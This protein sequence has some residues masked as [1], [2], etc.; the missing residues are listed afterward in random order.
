MEE[1]L[2]LYELI[3]IPS[4][5]KVNFTFNGGLSGS[6][7]VKLSQVKSKTNFIKNYFLLY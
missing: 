1:S 5:T 2:A 7:L 4:N 6:L 3:S